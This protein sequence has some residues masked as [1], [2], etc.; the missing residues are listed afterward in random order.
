MDWVGVNQVTSQTGAK[1]FNL[2]KNYMTLW[3]LNPYLAD[4]TQMQY[5]LRYRDIAICSNLIY[6]K[7]N[8]T[9]A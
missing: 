2:L 3:D 6:I 5:P 4:G 1:L 9:K 7:L 8:V